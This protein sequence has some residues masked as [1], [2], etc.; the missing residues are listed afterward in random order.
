MFSPYGAIGSAEMSLSDSNSS[1]NEIRTYFYVFVDR[2]AD[3]NRGS[4]SYD[5]TELVSSE[6]EVRRSLD[7]T[8]TIAFDRFTDEY[9]KEARVEINPE[10]YHP[11]RRAFGIQQLPAFGVSD[12]DLTCQDSL[13]SDRPKL[14]NWW[15]L[16]GHAERK[17]ILASEKF[18]PKVERA[19]I[20]HYS[21]TDDLYHFLRDLHMSNIDKGLSGVTQKIESDIRAVG[22]KKLLNVVST[23]RKVIVGSQ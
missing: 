23:G 11:T 20:S 15:N 8:V 22:G 16:L 1:Q 18:L 12:V 10:L 2:S 9:R 3:S 17:R 13:P 19:V 14:P 4:S 7:S 21:N 5:K 6:S